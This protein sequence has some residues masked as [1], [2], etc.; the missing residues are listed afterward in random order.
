MTEEE[1]KTKWCPMV[2]SL[3]VNPLGVCAANQAYDDGTQNIERAK[4]K[5]SQCM[6]WRSRNV[7]VDYNYQN[8][9]HLGNVITTRTEGYC[10]LAGKPE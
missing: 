4:C 6:M 2:R 8:R 7:E 10:G 3:V 5:G 1:A 9:D